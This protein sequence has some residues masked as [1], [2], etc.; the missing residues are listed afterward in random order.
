MFLPEPA[1]RRAGAGDGRAGGRRAGAAAVNGGR[2]WQMTDVTSH[3]QVEVLILYILILNT[4]SLI[5]I[6]NS[7]NIREY[8]FHAD[9][10]RSP[11]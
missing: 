4:Y 7:I 5:L 3:P 10:I 6:L 9:N 2:E 11:S 1:T 8:I